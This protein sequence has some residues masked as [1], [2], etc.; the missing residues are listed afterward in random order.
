MKSQSKVNRVWQG[1]TLFY[2]AFFAITLFLAYTGQLAIPLA[3][4][5]FDKVGHLVL[6]GIATF[7][8]H[9]G[10]KYCTIRL[11]AIRLTTVRLNIVRVPLFPLLF[12]LFTIAE[13]L[14]QAFSPNRTLDAIDLIFSCL[15]IGFG[16]WLAEK[17]RQS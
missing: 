7:L 13:E 2:T 1:I 3:D 14:F 4:P 8:G 16:Y 11:Q 12:T 17:C 15:G 5:P 9:R 6:Y 10:F